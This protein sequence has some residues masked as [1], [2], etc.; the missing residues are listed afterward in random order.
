[1]LTQGSY[2]TKKVS[3]LTNFWQLAQSTGDDIGNIVQGIN[4]LMDSAITRNEIM[5]RKLHT[6]VAS[7]GQSA[8]LEWQ[9]FAILFQRP[10][11][12]NQAIRQK[13]LNH[14]DKLT[15][16]IDVLLARFQYIEIK[17]KDMFELQFD[18]H[19]LIIGDGDTVEDQKKDKKWWIFTV[20][21]V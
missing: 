4:R 14:L 21:N 9:L 2:R 20:N 3:Q 6:F 10:L 1:M 8:S 13:Y 12:L 5:L 7:R 18:L 16:M 19:H 15:S 11:T 17:L